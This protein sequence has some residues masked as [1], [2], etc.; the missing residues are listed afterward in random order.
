MTPRY[1]QRLFETEGTTFSAYLLGQRLALAQRMLSD[2]RYAGWSIT[3]IAFE[4]GFGDLS[5]F[6]RAF[7]SRYG[8]TPS[9]FREAA[10]SNGNGSRLDRR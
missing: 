2:P 9:D 4:A 10:R 3:A 7:R 1:V 8:A 5:Y 6:A